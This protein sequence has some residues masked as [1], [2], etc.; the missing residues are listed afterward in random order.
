MAS[1]RTAL[2]VPL[3]ERLVYAG[4][5]AA[6]DGWHGTVAGAHLSGR[7]AAR[8]VAHAASCSRAV[9]IE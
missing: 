4:E 7:A 8:N 3:S 9:N 1:V 6:S 5:A 2:R